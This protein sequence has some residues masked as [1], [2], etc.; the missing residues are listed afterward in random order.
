MSHKA[1]FEL[2]QCPRCEG[3]CSRDRY[4]HIEKFSPLVSRELYSHLMDEKRRDI[5]RHH[6]NSRRSSALNIPASCLS[7]QGPASHPR[8]S[9][10]SLLHSPPPTSL[11][12][13]PNS[14]AKPRASCSTTVELSLSN[15]PPPSGSPLP[16]PP[17]RPGR[18]SFGTPR[19]HRRRSRLRDRPSVFQS[20][21]AERRDRSPAVFPSQQP[22]P[23][24]P[25]S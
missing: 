6:I 17:P 11:S 12:L 16:D 1:S 9:L 14:T 13:S 2:Q 15:P 19:R 22:T 18:L 3:Q 7:P 10:S 20:L 4:S 25:Q 24:A 21:T 23:S 5:L 8:A